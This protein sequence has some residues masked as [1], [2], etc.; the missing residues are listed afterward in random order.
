M[1]DSA[2]NE[3]IRIK[4]LLVISFAVLSGTSL[5]SSATFAENG[6]GKS[7]EMF[8]ECLALAKQGDAE[9]RY[10]LSFMYRTGS[11]VP[12]N[13]KKAIKWIRKA[14][15]QE[16][17]CAQTDLGIAYDTGKGGVQQNYK[18]AAKWYRKAVEQGHAKAQCNLGNMYNQ[19][20]GVPQDYNEAAKWYRKAAEQGV[21]D[22]QNSLGY[23]YNQGKGVPQDYK[24][25]AKWYRKA[26][27]QGLAIAQLNLGIRYA[28]GEGV[29][30]D[31]VESYAWLNISAAQGRGNAKHRDSVAKRLSPDA[32]A[33]A[34]ELSEEYYKKYVEPF[35]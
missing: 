16:Y 17:A 5:M 2:V 27:E 28:Q 15:K 8:E 22:A 30:Q 9:A 7:V 20:K 34:Q 13:H 29:L 35:Q 25:A 33:L 1:G 32:L 21:S 4:L 3:R 12:Q 23:M 26:A 19:G 18:K 11:G 24:E 14:A 31:Y 6:A 10:R